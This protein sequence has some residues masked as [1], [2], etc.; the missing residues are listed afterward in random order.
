MIKAW[1]RYFI[2]TPLYTFYDIKIKN[3]FLNE[4]SDNQGYFD[5]NDVSENIEMEENLVTQQQTLLW[6]EDYYLRIAPGKN[7][8]PK[9]LLFDAHTEEL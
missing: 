1:L 8:Y 3:D 4:I 6:N 2:N 5:I 7:N 9:S